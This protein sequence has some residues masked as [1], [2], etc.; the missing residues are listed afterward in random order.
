MP[1]TIT[2]AYEA[3]D[4]SIGED[5]SASLP[6]IVRGTTD[7]LEAA[8]QATNLVPSYYGGL[9]LEKVDY[10]KRLSNESHIVNADY[11]DPT[12][13]GD[14][15]QDSFE[16]N[17]DGQ[18]KN[19]KKSLQTMDSKNHLSDTDPAFDFGGMIGVTPNGADG[20]DVLIPKMSF[21]KSR[22][23]PAIQVES[24]FHKVLS[25]QLVGAVNTDSFY[26][27]EP[28]EV[29]LMGCRGT[30]VTQYEYEIF[31]DFSVSEN[32]TNLVV[33]NRTYVNKEGW[34]YLWLYLSEILQ[35]NGSEITGSIQAIKYSYI[36]RVYKR[37]LFSALQ[38]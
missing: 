1:I 22:K 35:F 2:R 3:A 5:N 10:D 17:I 8:I 16:F 26:S 11:A 6:Y 33:G 14:V 12:G 15:D 24:G 30:K 27:Y 18:I 9:V 38:L 19:I 25:K 4:I 37:S 36:D 28:G 13:I 20:V 23:Y 21:S 34:D 29:L 7:E 32:A 31:Y